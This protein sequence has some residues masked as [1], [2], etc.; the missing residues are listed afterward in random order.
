MRTIAGVRSAT[1]WAKGGGLVC[2]RE[3]GEPERVYGFNERLPGR[4]SDPNHAAGAEGVGVKSLPQ[5]TVLAC[6]RVLTRMALDYQM[7][8][9]LTTT[10]EEAVGPTVEDIQT[11]APDAFAKRFKRGGQLSCW[12]DR[13]L[14]KAVAAIGRKKII[15]AGLTTDI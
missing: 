6:C 10:M 13:A 14:T 4:L 3:Q 7:P 8:L 1:F 9:V 2:A 15:M 12:D 5:D 11:L